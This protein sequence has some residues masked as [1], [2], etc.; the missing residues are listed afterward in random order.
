M[1]ISSRALSPA[2]I[3]LLSKGLNFCPSSGNVNKFELYQDLDNFAR[4]LHLRGYFHGRPTESKKLLPAP[5][6]KMWTP[7]EQRDKHLNPYISAVQKDI[8]K[9]FE[10]RLP[11][12]SNLARDEREALKCLSEDTAIVIKSADKGGGGCGNYE[13]D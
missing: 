12:R 2:E 7:N 6:D 3:K 1:N 11:I 10:K 4:N 8:I 13:Q 9:E 5:S